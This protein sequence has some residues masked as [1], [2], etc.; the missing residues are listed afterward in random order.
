VAAVASD[1]GKGLNFALYLKRFN[2]QEYDRCLAA[3]GALFTVF[4]MTMMR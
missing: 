2:W 3:A 1:H 4:A